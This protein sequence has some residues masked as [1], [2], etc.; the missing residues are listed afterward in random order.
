MRFSTRNAF[1]LRV[2]NYRTIP[3][4]LYLD[5]RH[6][7]S[8]SLPTAF[9]TIIQ[10]PVPKSNRARPF[11]AAVLRLLATCQ[12]DSKSVLMR[13]RR[14]GWTTKLYNWSLQNYN[15]SISCSLTHRFPILHNPY[16]AFEG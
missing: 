14:I 6:V 10:T 13:N 16:S 11:P 15:Q 3:L 8:L 7:G 2:S 1:Y 12:F 9:E 4:F 5:E